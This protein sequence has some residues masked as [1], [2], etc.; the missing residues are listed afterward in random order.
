MTLTPKQAEIF[1]MIRDARLTDGFSPTMQELADG[2]GVSR[3]TVFEHVEALVKKGA[4]T[5]DKNKARSLA[6]AEDYALPTEMH[7]GISFPLMGRIAAGMPIER[8][9]DDETVTAGL[10]KG[11]QSLWEA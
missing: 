3:V 10:R 6:I 8:L 9:Q 4:L 11:L 2:L 1:R 7:D 5:R